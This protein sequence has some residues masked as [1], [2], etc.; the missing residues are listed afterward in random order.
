MELQ[1]PRPP[2]VN[3]RVC[4]GDLPENFKG[5]RVDDE[6]ASGAPSCTHSVTVWSCLS[7]PCCILVQHGRPEPKQLECPPKR[8]SPP[9]SG[10]KK[11]R[12]CVLAMIYHKMGEH[13]GGAR[14][15]HKH[16]G[17]IDW[18]GFLNLHI[19]GYWNCWTRKIF[20]LARGGTK[21]A[22]RAELL[23]Y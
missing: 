6:L 2:E 14:G 12:V 22:N 21:G 15:S 11:I 4:F 23:A 20:L 18:I 5:R 16:G 10:A 17:E 3:A 19:W 9:W 8:F 1:Q 7:P 13:G